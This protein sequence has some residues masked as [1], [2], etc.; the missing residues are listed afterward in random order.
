VEAI[1]LVGGQGTRL[2]PLTLTTPKPMLPVAGVPFLAHQLSRLKAAGVDHVVLAT[3][4]RPEVFEAH[5]G[6]GAALGLSLTYVTEAEPL[7]TGGGIRNAAA[8]LRTLGDEPV[9]V[10]NGDVLSGHDLSA[11][12]AFHRELRAVV[13]LHLV[14][15]EDARPYGCVPTDA[16]GRVTAF[17]EK[18]PEPVSNQ[19]NAGCYVLDRRV[20]EDIPAGTVVSVERDTFP[21]LLSA[22]KPL[23]G[24]VEDAYWLD[25][26]TPATYV[27]AGVDLVTGV[28]TSPAYAA[29]PAPAQLLDGA[30]V[31]TGATVT[32]GTSVGPGAVVEAGAVVTGSVLMA[33]CRVA[34]G[35][36]VTG[37]VVGVDAV[38][39]A[40]CVLTDVVL[41]D[42]ARLGARNELRDGA[43][44]WPRVVLPDVAVR[45]SSDV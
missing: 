37:S 34:A 4:Y 45:F 7:G 31:A 9:V 2:R 38:V 41:G 25:V 36:V 23:A 14:T 11:Q 29:P 27:Q 1:V 26:G 10:L 43:R 42:T 20:L 39:G 18:Q 28:A 17:L 16:H 3:S 40:G 21:A 6:G 15:V 13:T 35:A 44:V 12:I 30:A 22:G 33:G 19:I 8:A 32:G 5:F 24:Y